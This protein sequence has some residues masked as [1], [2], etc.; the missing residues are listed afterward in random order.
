MR[1]AI[2]P[3]RGGSTRIKKKNIRPFH[4]HPIIAYAIGCASACKL[5]DRII[6]STEDNE[7]AKVAYDYGAEWVRRDEALA[8]ND[9]GTQEV[10]K[11]VIATLGPHYDMACVIYPCTPLLIPDDLRMGY[12]ACT[13]RMYSMS[14]GAHPLRDAGAFYWG[15]TRAF[16]EGVP[17]IGVNTAMVPLPEHRVCDINTLE[18]FQRAEQLYEE[19]LLREKV[20]A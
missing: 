9:V 15:L 19:G 17:L 6:V 4:G 13:G 8:H 10:A 20:N 2:I 1:A 5:F 14:V 16:L 7:I 3:A 12:L 18:D 11:S